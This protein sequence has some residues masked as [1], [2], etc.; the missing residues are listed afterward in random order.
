MSSSPTKVN[1]PLSGIV[2]GNG[3]EMRRLHRFVQGH[4]GYLLKQG[5]VFRQWRPRYFVLEKRKLMI[6]NDDSMSNMLGEVIIHDNMQLYDVFEEV[7]G[8]KNLFYLVGKSIQGNE[9]LIF[10]SA[11]TEKDKA[12]WMEALLDAVHDGFR[13]ICNPDVWNPT[14]DQDCK[15][16]P[17][18]DMIILYKGC[19][20]AENGIELRSGLTEH[21][22]EII[23]K[24]VG[25]EERFAL[26][27]IDADPISAKNGF[28]LHWCIINIT[29]S[30][31]KTGDEVSDTPFQC[32]LLQILTLFIYL[33]FIYIA[34]SHFF[35][36]SLSPCG[37]SLSLSLFLSSLYYRSA[38]MSPPLRPTAPAHTATCSCSSNT[39]ASPP[40]TTR[41]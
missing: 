4:R 3:N 1:I 13:M 21:P 30:D 37:L 22:P 16:Y 5:K 24:N 28:Y 12:E 6:Y 14:P 33:S 8:K 19:H 23:L 34:P 15:F 9:E 2:T 7:E 38:S 18:V 26:I 10:V 36:L 31:I 35:F 25:N 20:W 11:L 41:T 29:G 40:F 39:A 32:L 17:T 27:M